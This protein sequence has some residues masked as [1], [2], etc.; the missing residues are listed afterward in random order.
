MGKL[1]GTSGIRGVSNK[2]LKPD[3]VIKV[4]QST[5]TESGKGVVLVAHDT[6][7]TS[8]MF[9]N[10]IV[11]GLLSCGA[12]VKILGLATT[13]TLAYL[14][15]ALNAKFG[16][17][18]TASHNPPEYNGIK[19][20]DNTGMAF[21]EIRE[22]KIEDIFFSG[23]FRYVDWDNI[24]TSSQCEDEIEKYIEF[25]SN[26]VSFDKKWKLA[27]DFGCGASCHIAPEIFKRLNV[28]LIS[29]N[30]HPDGVFPSRTSEPTQSSSK[31]LCKVVKELELD[32]GVVYDGDA[33]RMA[34]IDENGNFLSMDKAL[35]AYTAY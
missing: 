15:K 14:T 8:Q 20:F 27:V 24:K 18:L 16:I 33:D 13:P 5:V 9:L 1:F 17:M 35:A 30:A 11:A 4:G 23:Q 32:A 34:I 31:D 12:E 25:I 21:N 6:R 7:T 22:N 10:A 2:D 28:D 26:A 29:M 3:L 19:L